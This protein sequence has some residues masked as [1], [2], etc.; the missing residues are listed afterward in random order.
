[1]SISGLDWIDDPVRRGRFHDQLDEFLL[2]VQ[3]VENVAAHN[4]ETLQHE[5]AGPMDV[6]ELPERATVGPRLKEV[7]SVEPSVEFA[8]EQFDALRA[9]PPVGPMWEWLGERAHELVEELKQV[10]AKIADLG[11]S[12]SNDSG[13]GT[14]D[15][16]SCEGRKSDDTNDDGESLEK[17]WERGLELLKRSPDSKALAEDLRGRRYRA[18][19]DELLENRDAFPKSSYASGSVTKKVRR[20]NETWS[21]ARPPVPL[22]IEG[23]ERSGFLAEEKI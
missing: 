2:Y 16:G 8:L 22:Y 18:S 10:D 14:R 9:S 13:R 23:D 1:M 3:S 15:A 4:A 12:G 5:F 7:L 6:V 20:I 17:A 21:K 11:G 19:K